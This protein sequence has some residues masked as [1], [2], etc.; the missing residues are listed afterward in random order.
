MPALPGAGSR[1]FSCSRTGARHCVAV[2]HCDRRPGGDR[3]RREGHGHQHGHRPDAHRDH[4]P[5][6]RLCV[7]AAAGRLIQPRRGADRVPQIRAKRYPVAG[8][9]ERP[10]GREARCRQRAGDGHRG[11][12]GRHGRYARRHAE[13]HRRFQTR[14]GTPLERTEPGRPGAAGAGRHAGGRQHGRSGRQRLASARPERGERQRFPQQ[15]LALYPSTAGPTWT[16]W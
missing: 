15:Q 14:C 10:S 2:R 1:A 11:G 4:R 3:A 9:R 12:A 5:E 13:P 8:Q 7:H 16:T 6:R